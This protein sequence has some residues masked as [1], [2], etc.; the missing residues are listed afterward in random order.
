M[1]F[2]RFFTKYDY[3]LLGIQLSETVLKSKLLRTEDHNMLQIMQHKITTD[4]NFE[5]GEIHCLNFDTALFLK[6]SQFYSHNKERQVEYL[7][8]AQT[9]N[10]A[11]LAIDNRSIHA[12]AN[13]AMCFI[14]QQTDTDVKLEVLAHTIL[15][16]QIVKGK[17]HYMSVVDY[18]FSSAESVRSEESRLRSCKIFTDALREI[19]ALHDS[20]FLSAYCT[21]FHA[22]VLI[23]RAQ[24]RQ[25]QRNRELVR[26]IVNEAL[27]CLITLFRQDVEEFNCDLWIWLAELQS[28]KVKRIVGTDFMRQCISRYQREVGMDEYVN[29][30]IAFCINQGEQ[31]MGLLGREPRFVRRIAKQYLDLA[32]GSSQKD[33]K[34]NFFTR[35][36]DVSNPLV[37]TSHPLFMGVTTNTKARMSIWGIRFYE[38]HK[39]EVDNDFYECFGHQPG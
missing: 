14:Y 7:E 30:D 26:N 21:Y 4:Q 12:V 11:V 20:R 31:V 22:K 1:E 3:S 33:D 38:L 15:E 9:Y 2:V 6:G 17:H 16:L 5:R 8:K 13:R 28:E 10:D 18:A 24:A 39:Q 27:E 32:D 34:I 23:R 35:A 29:L 25:N 19:Q 36:I 37:Q